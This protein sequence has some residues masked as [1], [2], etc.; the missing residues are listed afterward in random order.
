VRGPRYWHLLVIAAVAFAVY[1]NTLSADFVWD[2][3][4]Q[5]VQNPVIKDPYLVPKFFT[6][7]V[8]TLISPTHPTNYY[9]P[10]MF[11]SYLITYHLFGLNPAGFHF[12]NIAC[13][14]LVALMVYALTLRLFERS[15]IA[16]IA[17]LLFAVHPIHTEAVA[18]VAS[19]PE[20]LTSFF[21]VL[22][23]YLY[24]R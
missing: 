17:G 5:V 23:F 1:L 21:Y 20:L 10:T 12:V 15:E 14:A 22:S 8:W 13:N 4:F 24:L 11:V 7:G 3:R 16:L 9:R 6:T 18:W 2:D 19:V